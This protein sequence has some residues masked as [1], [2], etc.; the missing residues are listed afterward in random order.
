MFDRTKRILKL[1]RDSTFTNPTSIVPTDEALLELMDELE[2]ELNLVKAEARAY[3]PPPV[4]G[5]AGL[6]N[7]QAA[8]EA[9]QRNLATL[10]DST[11]VKMEL[12]PKTEEE[13]QE[14]IRLRL[15]TLIT[16]LA[17]VSL[18][19]VKVAL[20]GLVPYHV[21]TKPQGCPKCGAELTWDSDRILCTN[22][23]CKYQ[24]KHWEQVEA[25]RYA[26]GNP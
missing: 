21:K 2:A 16:G 12:I 1:W 9:R 19:K 26:G 4:Y 3:T 8:E 23:V 18:T 14:E 11:R 15:N 25:D 6:V 5:S 13:L 10:R 17:P 7:D 20:E 22:Q 24:R